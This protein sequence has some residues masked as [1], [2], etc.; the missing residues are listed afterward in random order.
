[1]GISKIRKLVWWK[2]DQMEREWE[3]KRRGRQDEN[4]KPEDAYSGGGGAFL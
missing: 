4:R 1:M 2:T 3:E